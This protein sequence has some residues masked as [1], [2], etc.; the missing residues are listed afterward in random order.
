MKL[1]SLLFWVVFVSWCFILY[2]AANSNSISKPSY[3]D[4][5]LDDAP[6]V[7]A[8][9]LLEFAEKHLGTPYHYGGKSPK[10]FDCSGF[11]Y[12][13]YQQQGIQ[14]PRS[15]KN[16]INA[17]IEIPYEQAQK[18]DLIVFTGSD[19]KKREPGHVGIVVSKSPE[20]LTFI[21]SSSSKKNNGIVYSTIP[22]DKETTYKKRF[23]QIRRVFK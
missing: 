21:H 10:G 12:Y 5:T 8:D 1:N 6:P 23:L 18:G 2:G 9:K 7:E 22:V 16:Q 4:E 14:I 13:C 3:L 20:E 19:F 15:S 17:G 11:T